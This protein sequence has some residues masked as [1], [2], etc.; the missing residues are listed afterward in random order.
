MKKPR[1]PKHLRSA[2]AILL[3]S[4]RGNPPQVVGLTEVLAGLLMASAPSSKAAV[5]LLRLDL[6]EL[7]G[8]ARSDPKTVVQDVC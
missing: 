6:H 4:G 1:G 5:W 3:R 2:A 7:V 8:S